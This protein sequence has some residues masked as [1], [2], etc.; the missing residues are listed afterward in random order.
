MTLHLA[1]ADGASLSLQARAHGCSIA[2]RAILRDAV[3]AMTTSTACID[4]AISR[5]WAAAV[6]HVCVAARA[7]EDKFET[8]KNSGRCNSVSATDILGDTEAASFTTEREQ[9]AAQLLPNTHGVE[10]LSAP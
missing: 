4:L 10:F 3:W 6:F 7:G 2:L 5:D 9:D 1:C 8:Y